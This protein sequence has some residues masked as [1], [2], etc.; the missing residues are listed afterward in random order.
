MSFDSMTAWTAVTT[1]AGAGCGTAG[2]TSSPAS[3]RALARASNFFWSVG[4]ANAARHLGDAKSRPES[5]MI[6]DESGTERWAPDGSVNEIGPA[7]TTWGV[8]S[9]IAG[10]QNS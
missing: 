4:F 6:R 10:S 3:W 5:V 8:L 7:P 9:V 1:T 2:D